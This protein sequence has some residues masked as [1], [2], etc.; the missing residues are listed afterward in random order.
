[1][2]I[3]RLPLSAVLLTVLLPLV[4]SIVGI[5]IWQ[6]YSKSVEEAMSAGRQLF[7]NLQTDVA[8][9]Q[10]ALLGHVTDSARLVWNAASVGLKVHDLADAW[11]RPLDW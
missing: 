2:I 7:S 9:Q 6:S 5:V 4:G 11:L 3:R 1:M 8:L 10:N